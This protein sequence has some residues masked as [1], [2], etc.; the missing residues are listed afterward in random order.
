MLQKV[1][2]KVLSLFLTNAGLSRQRPEA[3]GQA[4]ELYDF[5]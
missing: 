1:E 4:L 5:L 2:L 3:G